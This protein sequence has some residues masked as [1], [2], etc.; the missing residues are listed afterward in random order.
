VALQL[1]ASAEVPAPAALVFGLISS[2]ERLPEWNTSVTTA[3]RLDAP[4]VPVALGSR[5]VFS[6][7]LLGQPLESETQVV[8]FDPPRLFATRGI[9]GPRLETTF[10]LESISAGT[11]VL[12]E[13]SGEVPGGAIGSLLA[14]RFLRS[15]LS[16]SLERLRTLCAGE[17][18]A[19]TA[20]ESPGGDPACWL[21]LQPDPQ[22]QD[23]G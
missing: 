20:A 16:A 18:R 7:R 2:P 9:R 4:D 13:V 23:I 15:E 14:E 22:R 10:R 11:L 12:V 5:A 6:G 19:A 3:R 8:A 17:A 21:H 1:R